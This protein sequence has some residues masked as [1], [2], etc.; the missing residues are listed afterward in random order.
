GGE[1][2]APVL[3]LQLGQPVLPLV[4]ELRRHGELPEVP[5]KVADDARH[6]RRDEPP[7]RLELP[8]DGIV[9][10]VEGQA[11]GQGKI[12][13]G[14]HTYHANSPAAPAE[15]TAVG[16]GKRERDGRAATV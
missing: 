13:F 8:A 12:R 2:P 16:S 4:D 15:G 11:L 3:D 7:G 9:D 6:V 10:L 14:H 5:V 1:K